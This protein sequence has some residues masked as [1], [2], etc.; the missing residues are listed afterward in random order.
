MRLNMQ[1]QPFFARP[2]GRAVRA[3]SLSFVEKNGIKNV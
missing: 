3:Y 2:N 1:R